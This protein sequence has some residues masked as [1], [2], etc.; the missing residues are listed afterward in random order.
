[1]PGESKMPASPKT[2]HGTFLLTK[3]AVSIL[4]G[5]VEL[6]GSA[7]RLWSRREVAG[8]PLAGELGCGLEHAALLEQV[9]GAGHHR[10][11]ALA[12]QL[13][14]GTPVEVEDTSSWPPMMSRVG[15]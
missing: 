15:R 3:S 12:P 14:L 1:M 5:E 7:R 2:S 9:T 8:E 10:G 4:N 13:S 11:S 6:H